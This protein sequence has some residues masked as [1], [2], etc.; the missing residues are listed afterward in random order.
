MEPFRDLREYMALLE[1]SGELHRIRA[2]VDWDLELGA[3]TRRVCNRRGP[4]LLFEN[5][6]GYRNSLCRRLFT[7]GPGTRERVNLA[8]GLPKETPYKEIVRGLKERWSQPLDS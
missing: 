6:K 5:I 2:E 8:L 7:N 4:A 1:R 3:I